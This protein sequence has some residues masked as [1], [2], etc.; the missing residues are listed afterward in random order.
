MTKQYQKIKTNVFYNNV[1]TLKIDIE[2]NVIFIEKTK[3]VLTELHIYF[4]TRTN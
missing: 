2:I 3:Y 4:L 1:K